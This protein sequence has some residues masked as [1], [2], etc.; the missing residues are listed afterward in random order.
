MTFCY[1][2][3]WWLS[4][5]TLYWWR[6]FVYSLKITITSFHW[7]Y[8]MI[9]HYL[10][11]FSIKRII[12]KFAVGF[13]IENNNIITFSV[14]YSVTSDVAIRFQWTFP[15]KVKSTCSHRNSF[16]ILHRTRCYKSKLIRYN[17]KLKQFIMHN[18]NKI[19]WFE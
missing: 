6:G 2:I 14:I 18:K 5:C 1:F 8:I 13:H 19:F 16:K 12:F 4:V 7:Y 15:N 3:L 11:N 10:L 9:Y 17:Y